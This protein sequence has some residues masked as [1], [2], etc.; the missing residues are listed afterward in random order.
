LSDA[1]ADKPPALLIVDPIVS[2]VSGD[3]HKNAEVRRSLQPLVDLA[4]SRRCAVLG[5]SHFS[6]GS[7]GADPVERVTGSLAFGALAR[8]VLATAKLP[9]EEGGGRMLARAKSNIGLDHGGFKYELDVY[10]ID[11]GIET[12][13]VLWGEALEGSARELLSKAEASSDPEEQT[14]TDEAREWLREMLSAGPMKVADIR[15]EARQAGIHEKPLR[16]AREKLGIKPEK[17][18][19][20]GGWVWA[21]KSS[22]DE[23]STGDAAAKMPSMPEDAQNPCQ[24][25]RASWEGEGILGDELS[26]GDDDAEAF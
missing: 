22:A 19:F 18:S 5:I 25:M 14:A 20:S 4:Q 10:Q 16:S 13:R 1:V 17:S 12:T 9:N 2:A 21:L 8:I 3:S 23:L 7:K 11:A 15:K 24:E 6:K 26:T